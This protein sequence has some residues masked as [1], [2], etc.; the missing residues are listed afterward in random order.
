MS[1]DFSHEK[2]TIGWNFP[3]ISTKICYFCRHL[4]AFYIFIFH[5]LCL[6]KQ[7]DFLVIVLYTKL[8]AVVGYFRKPR[9]KS[10]VTKGK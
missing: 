10:R 2:G 8:M 9:G 3:F 1:G 5:I 7:L 4:N 6:V